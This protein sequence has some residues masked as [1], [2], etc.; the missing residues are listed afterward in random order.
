MGYCRYCVVLAYFL[1]I[2]LGVKMSFELRVYN[3]S[4]EVIERVIE[5]DSEEVLNRTKTFV[6][7]QT[8]LDLEPC[9]EGKPLPDSSEIEKVL[10]E[11]HSLRFLVE[12]VSISKT[13][14]AGFKA[15][16]F[17]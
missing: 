16:K 15:L 10:L 13:E 11:T 3:E 17:H 2:F 5:C 9:R 8:L 7:R 1:R 14:F 4:S 12:R 6:L